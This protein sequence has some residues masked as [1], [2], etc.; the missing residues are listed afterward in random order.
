MRS[1]NNII[2]E[3]T[4]SIVLY[5]KPHTKTKFL[6]DFINSYKIPVFYV[7]F[8]LLFSYQISDILINLF[9]SMNS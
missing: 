9:S 2:D 3:K 5:S 7:D 8:D 4:I 6:N 1:I